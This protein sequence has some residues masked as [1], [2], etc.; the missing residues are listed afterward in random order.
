MQ[1]SSPPQRRFDGGTI[2]EVPLNLNGRYEIIRNFAA[3][4]YHHSSAATCN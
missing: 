4:R 3:V 2:H 1:T